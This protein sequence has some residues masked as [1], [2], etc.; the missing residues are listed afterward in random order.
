MCIAFLDIRNIRL[1]D[2][3]TLPSCPL[4]SF[5]LLTIE[6]ASIIHY[7]AFPTKEIRQKCHDI[8]VSCL[9]RSHHSIS[10]K[11]DANSFWQG[12]QALSENKW[13]KIYSKK[14]KK[15]R[16][17]LNSRRTAFDCP[18]FESVEQCETHVQELLS[19]LLSFESLEFVQP[20]QF[21]E[22]L[23]LASGLK[24]LPLKRLNKSEA[25]TFCICVNI[26]HVL[27]LHALLLF[28]VPSK[29]SSDQML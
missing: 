9:A 19:R 2:E 20:N 4:V 6:T 26:Y 16:I 14:K 24:N 13:T 18:Y 17:V 7:I 29:V 1:I 5:P 21:V 25:S 12:F 3:Y 11:D 22:F 28:G 15:S 10:E 27:L 8:L 23:D